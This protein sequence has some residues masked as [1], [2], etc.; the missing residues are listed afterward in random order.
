MQCQGAVI[1]SHDGCIAL[2]TISEVVVGKSGVVAVFLAVEV[3]DAVEGLVIEVVVDV[4]LVVVLVIEVVDVTLVVVVVIVIEVVVDVMLVEE[5]EDDG[6]LKVFVVPVT[7]I[8]VLTLMHAHLHA[9]VCDICSTGMLPD[10]HLHGPGPAHWVVVVV[11]GVGSGGSVAWSFVCPCLSSLFNTTL[12]SPD[13]SL[14]SASLP[15]LGSAAIAGTVLADPTG[16]GGGGGSPGSRGG[17]VEVDET[18]ILVVYVSKVGKIEDV[19]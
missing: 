15:C 6:R 1:A 11:V 19:W 12:S 4:T 9:P 8:V 3:D 18:V 2:P 16:G 17:G 13:P 5:D 14:P 10:R 7:V